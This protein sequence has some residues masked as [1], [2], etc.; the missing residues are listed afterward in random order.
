MGRGSGT[1]DDVLCSGPIADARSKSV[2]TKTFNPSHQSADNNN[3]LKQA[4]NALSTIISVGFAMTGNPSAGAA[5]AGI[6]GMVD[7]VNMAIST[8]QSENLN[9]LARVADIAE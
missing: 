9:N 1:Y 2:L 3:A 5:A 4:L 6:A 8:A 7:R